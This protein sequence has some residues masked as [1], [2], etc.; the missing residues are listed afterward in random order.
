[1]ETRIKETS[2]DS[3]TIFSI[4]IPLYNTR[5]YLARCL[6]S[7]INQTF[8][9]IEIIIVDDCGNDGSIGIAQDYAKRDKR[10]KIIHN[11]HNLGTFHSRIEGMKMAQG[12]YVLFLDSDDY[13]SLETCSILHQNILHSPHPLDVIVF[14]ME[15]CSWDQPLLDLDHQS[16]QA[17]IEK[18]YGASICARAY[19]Q[20][21][22]QQT[23]LALSSHFP[24]IPRLVMHEDALL[25]FILLFFVQYF[26]ITEEILYF[27]FP[28]PQ[29]TT[30]AKD[31]KRFRI[32]KRNTQDIVRLF[33]YFDSLPISKAPH[34]THF[35][36]RLHTDLSNKVK[37][38]K[39]HQTKH[40]FSKS[41]KFSSYIASQILE[42]RYNKT[43]KNFIK[44][45]IKISIYLS[46]LGK[47]KI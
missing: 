47:K 39:Y 12:S 3:K 44:T 10:I 28:N 24:P 33:T 32:Y 21:I 35:K 46:T 36:N 9:D 13:I 43:H 18:F 4:I 41:P 16:N 8:E 11:P 23:L 40:Y 19:S 31:K 25:C 30:R 1:M 6:D 38:Y 17:L 27:Y 15:G 37:E 45:M 34:F 5:P 7:A 29:S 22:I 26:E 42:F 2:Q 14:N 20:S